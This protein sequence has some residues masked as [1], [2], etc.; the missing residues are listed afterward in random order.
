MQCPECGCT[1]LLKKGI[2]NNKQRYRCK[3]C[4]RFFVEGSK[5]S[6]KEILPPKQC[7]Y[8]GHTSTQRKGIL[9]DGTQRYMCN[10]CNRSFSSKSI[11]KTE[12]PYP[13]PYCGGKLKRKGKG[14]L[15]Q[16]QYKCAQCNKSCSGDPPVKRVIFSQTSRDILCPQCGSYE[17]IKAGC[18]RS[19]KQRYKCNKC[20]KLFV[21]LDAEYMNSIRE[22]STETCP[23]C[24]GK[25]IISA[26]KTSAGNQRYRCLSCRRSYTKNIVLIKDRKIKQ[27]DKR[28]IIMYYLQGHSC[29]ELSMYFG[30][31]R[32]YIQKLIKDFKQK[33]KD[34][35]NGK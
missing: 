28:S 10:H 8:C 35:I 12:V 24:G 3:Q 2:R 4:G 1:E 25:K 18:S 32:Y 16:N 22:R 17:L 33:N 21:Q 29:T 30:Y 5:Y 11:I 19:G 27:K 23:Y 14:K 15:G 7:P 13:C 31:S 26:G 6:T 20:N 9:E 34:R